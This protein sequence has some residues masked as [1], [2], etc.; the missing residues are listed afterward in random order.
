MKQE[1]PETQI[2][3]IDIRYSDSLNAFEC[4]Y[5]EHISYQEIEQKS[6]IEFKELLFQNIS[7]DIKFRKYGRI[8]QV[9]TI[10]ADMLKSELDL[11]KIMLENDEMKLTHNWV[12]CNIDI[13]KDGKL[14]MSNNKKSEDGEDDECDFEENNE[15]D[16]IE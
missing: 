2:I 11:F 9:L 13:I 8:G 14:N 6:Y 12:I 5:G 3:L 4:W 15:L 7:R 16:E 1:R 10:K